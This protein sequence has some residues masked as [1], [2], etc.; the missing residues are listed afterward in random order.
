MAAPFTIQDLNHDG[1]SARVAFP[2]CVDGTQYT[3]IIPYSESLSEVHSIAAQ[4]ASDNLMTALRGKLRA[5][6]ER[7]W[8]LH[9]PS[10]ETTY[11]DQT[12]RLP[13]LHA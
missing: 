9:D 7:G 12:S 10:S 2:P 5:K 11:D 1:Q 13:R 6:L 4:L 8:T 3:F